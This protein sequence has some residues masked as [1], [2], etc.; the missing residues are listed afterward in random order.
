V[1]VNEL[2]RSSERAVLYLQAL[3]YKSNIAR[4]DND[5]YCD[6]Y[7][8][9]SCEVSQMY[10]VRLR[11]QNGNVGSRCQ[12]CT[13]TRKILRYSSRYFVAKDG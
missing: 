10:Y 5:G 1:L 6:V 13:M 8:L 7:S 12:G 2:H 3:P 9:L 4:R 11:T